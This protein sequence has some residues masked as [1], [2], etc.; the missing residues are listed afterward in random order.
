[1]VE[2][3][4]NLESSC[5]SDSIE[6]SP[7]SENQCGDDMIVTSEEEDGKIDIE[8]ISQ[9]PQ[10]VDDDQLIKPNKNLGRCTAPLWL[11]KILMSRG[12]V[13][14]AQIV[15]DIQRLIKKGGSENQKQIEKIVEKVIRS[16]SDGHRKIEI[17]IP[18]VNKA[19]DEIS[20]QEYEQQSITWEEKQM[21][22]DVR[23]TKRAYFQSEKG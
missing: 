23:R 9:T 14:T 22:S 15:E 1:M 13:V 2:V 4:S 17:A 21:T 20:A 16:D 7:L 5:Y 10:V 6:Y 12:K 19:F 18:M 11:R 3:S 8:E